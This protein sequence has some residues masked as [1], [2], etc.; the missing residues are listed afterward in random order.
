MEQPKVSI[1][2]WIFMKSE[3]GL[4]GINGYVFNVSSEDELS[5]GYYQNN[6]KA[7]KEQVIWKDDRWQFKHSGPNGSYLTGRDAAIVKAGPPRKI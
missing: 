2:D 1:G 5:V 3:N 7:I 4:S 6:S